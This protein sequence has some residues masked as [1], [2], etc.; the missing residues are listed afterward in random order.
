MVLCLS[1][2]QRW[3][4]TS[5][6]KREMERLQH[7]MINE[8]RQAAEVHRQASYLSRV[9]LWQL[10]MQSD[11]AKP[12]FLHLAVCSLSRVYL[13]SCLSQ[14]THFLRVWKGGVHR[15]TNGD[16][17]NWQLG[18]WGTRMTFRG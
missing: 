5:E 12:W 1:H 6:E 8:V 10:I 3:R 15:E 2:S 4:E 17:R 18:T 16:R 9:R 7:D 11:D 13:L 14:I